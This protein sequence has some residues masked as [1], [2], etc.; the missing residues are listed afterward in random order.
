MNN[1][2]IPHGIK[3]AI[4]FTEAY[5]KHEKDHIA[6]REA[7]CL[8]TQF[9][10]VLLPIGEQ[11]I[12]AGK[13]QYAPVGMHMS[14]S[15]GVCGYY[16]D[17]HAIKSELQKD[18]LPQE[19]KDELTNLLFFWKDRTTYSVTKSMDA[20]DADSSTGHFLSDDNRTGLS[21]ENVMRMGVRSAGYS[22][23]TSGINLNYGRLLT[24]GIQGLRERSY[25]AYV[26]V[27][28]IGRHRQL[29]A[30]GCVF[31]RFLLQ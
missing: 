1:H 10:N 26:A 19:L 11:D 17:K 13:C 3:T 23:R 7:M 6:I 2:E 27:L 29:W 31:G 24:L 18:G 15:A 25:T 8:K 14:S 22:Y 12:F 5:K 21:D 9:P 16:C 28:L 30:Y 20:N 4:E